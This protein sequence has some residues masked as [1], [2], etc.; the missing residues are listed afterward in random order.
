MSSFVIGV[1]LTL[2]Q[3]RKDDCMV[4]EHI[5]SLWHDRFA[6]DKRYKVWFEACTRGTYIMRVSNIKV[7]VVFS[8][9]NAYTRDV[10]DASIFS[11]LPCYEITPCGDGW[12]V[13]YQREVLI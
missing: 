9:D 12:R 7:L 13:E 1:G 8:G 11:E 2:A 4:W 10:S 6:P 5:N 3:A